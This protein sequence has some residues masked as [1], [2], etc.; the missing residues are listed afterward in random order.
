MV[1]SALD[2]ALDRSIVLGYSRVGFELRRRAW[3]GRGHTLPRLDGH[4]VAL[5]GATSGLGRAA[6]TGLWLL[7]ARLLLLVRS[8]ERG[9]KVADEL[10]ASTGASALDAGRVRVI[11]CDLGDLSSVR[12]CAGELLHG[13]E[14]VDVLINNAGVMPGE[15]TMSADGIELTFA[16]NVV[17]PFLLTNLLEPALA[18]ASARE[19]GRGRVITVSSGGAYGQRIHVD[20]LEMATEDYSGPTAYARSKRAEIILS[21]MWAQRWR[22][23]SIGAHAMHPGWADTPG[24]QD[25]LPRFRQLTKPLLRSPAQGADTIVWLAAADAPSLGTGGFWHDRRRRPTHLLPRTRESE[26][27]RAQLWQL[28]CGLSGWSDPDSEASA[29]SSQP[30]G[31]EPA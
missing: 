23:E 3:P 10:R 12:R 22:P 14:S 4:T 2:T 19:P 16:T 27:D 11:H 9:Q 20:D 26:A 7:G 15:R 5:S 21:E 18:A 13:D 30:A 31:P 28:L 24:V 1:N 29:E 17:G 6:A 8:E 25:A